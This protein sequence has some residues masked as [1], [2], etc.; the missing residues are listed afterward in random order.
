[1][2]HESLKL[3]LTKTFNFI[4]LPHIY[5][6]TATTNLQVIASNKI[7]FITITKGQMKSINQQQ[8]EDLG[9][10]TMKHNKRK[11]ERDEPNFIIIRNK[12]CFTLLFVLLL[13]LLLSRNPLCI[14]NTSFFM[15]PLKYHLIRRM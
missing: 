13:L 9:H 11:R 14:K 2:C 7:V 3:F 4:L 6:I 8:K 1:M 5:P 10:P 12:F 15:C